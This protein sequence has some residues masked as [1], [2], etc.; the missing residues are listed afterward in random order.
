MGTKNGFLWPLSLTRVIG[1]TKQVYV[2]QSS[3]IT[4]KLLLG[5]N[6]KSLNRYNKNKNVDILLNKTVHFTYIIYKVYVVC[7]M[8]LYV[9]KK[10]LY[11]LEIFSVI[12]LYQW[13]NN[14]NGL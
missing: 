14:S 5:I 1:I 13:Y 6:F 4:K 3:V 12:H 2:D 9:I 11:S 7:N 8:Y 10:K